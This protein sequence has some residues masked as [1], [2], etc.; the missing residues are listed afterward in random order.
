MSSNRHYRELIDS[1]VTDEGEYIQI[2]PDDEDFN[3]E[4]KIDRFGYSEV[5]YEGINRIGDAEQL[6]V[7]IFDQAG[8][9]DEVDYLLGG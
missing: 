7:D 4:H 2:V 8:Q 1:F 5:L 3:I 6:V 9:I